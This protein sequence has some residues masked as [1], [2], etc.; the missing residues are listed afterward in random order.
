MTALVKLSIVIEGDVDEAV[1][2]GTAL[3]DDLRSLDGVHS[4]FI[5]VHP[6]HGEHDDGVEDEV[7]KFEVASASSQDDFDVTSDGSNHRLTQRSSVIHER[8]TP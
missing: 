6:A 1:R 4:V 2:E 7:V 3:A 8:G 5:D